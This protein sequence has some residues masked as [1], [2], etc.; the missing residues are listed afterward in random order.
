MSAATFFW[1]IPVLAVCGLVAAATIPFTSIT[2]R[3]AAHL[4]AGVGS[5]LG[6]GAAALVV[7]LGTL[8]TVDQLNS[9][10]GVLGGSVTGAG[11]MSFSSSLSYGF[12]ALLGGLAVI[13]IGGILVLARR[14]RPVRAVAPP[15]P[16]PVL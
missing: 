7:V 9:Y 16:A 14:D 15:T 5:Q 1:V 6:A 13:L 4:A 11:G 3:T 12:Y 2:A 8:Q 10:M